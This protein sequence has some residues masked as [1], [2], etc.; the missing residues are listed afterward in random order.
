MTVFAAKTTVNNTIH[1]V[2]KPHTFYKHSMKLPLMELH[3]IN[4]CLS[5]RI[6]LN[7]D[8]TSENK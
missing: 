2:Q 4:C 8:N 6:K 7:T 3:L 1:G 5:T